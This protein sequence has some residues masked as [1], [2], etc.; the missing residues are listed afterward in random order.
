[1]AALVES[2]LDISAR[3]WR[4]EHPAWSDDDL[5]LAT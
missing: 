5:P 4:R 2:R 1:L 3:A